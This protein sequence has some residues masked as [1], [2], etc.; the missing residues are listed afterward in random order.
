MG[1]GG[2]PI[3]VSSMPHSSA[4]NKME[5]PQTR[6]YAAQAGALAKTRRPDMRLKL[7]RLKVKSED[8]KSKKH[9]RN[10]QGASKSE[11]NEQSSQSS[12]KLPSR[13]GKHANYSVR[14]NRLYSVLI[15]QF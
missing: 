4:S 9:V 1:G 13:P 10:G 7:A 14:G 12:K 3:I 6:G 8:P 2:S 15:Q 5:T 11:E